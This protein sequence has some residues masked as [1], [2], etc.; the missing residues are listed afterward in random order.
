MYL[1]NHLLL[2]RWRVVVAEDTWAGMFAGDFREGFHI[3]G[4][5]HTPPV[6]YPMLHATPR[7]Y[8]SPYIHHRRD[9]DD[10]DQ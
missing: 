2:R 1:A 6:P 9:A 8:P 4:D 7:L 5:A 10:A 3:K